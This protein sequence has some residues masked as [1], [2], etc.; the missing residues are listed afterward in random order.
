M[1][2]VSSGCVQNHLRGILALIQKLLYSTA[3][4][5]PREKRLVQELIF[6]GM[7]DSDLHPQLVKPY[8]ILPTINNQALAAFAVL[9]ADKICIVFRGLFDH[10]VIDDPQ[11]TSCMIAAGTEHF[12]YNI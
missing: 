11:L 1:Q 8:R 12:I 10:I 5:V 7:P 3:Y 9:S 6:H 2:R 4:I